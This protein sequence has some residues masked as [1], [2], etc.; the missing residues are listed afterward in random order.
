MTVLEISDLIKMKEE[1]F[2]VQ[3]AAAA[4][5][6]LPPLPL[7][8]PRTSSNRVQRDP[9]ELRSDQEDRCHQGSP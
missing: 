9:E 8:P 5:A 1:K 2:G 4:A 7:V 6:L 3:A